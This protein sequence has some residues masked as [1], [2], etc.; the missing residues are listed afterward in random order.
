[1]LRDN[2]ARLVIAYA[3]DDSNSGGPLVAMATDSQ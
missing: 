1:M 2:L 3:L